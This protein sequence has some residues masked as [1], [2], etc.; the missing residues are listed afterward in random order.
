MKKPP[1]PGRL[2]VFPSLSVLGFYS[3][4]CIILPWSLIT[5][6]QKYKL[7]KFLRKLS[8]IF[9]GPE[10]WRISWLFVETEQ[11]L[12]LLGVVH[13]AEDTTS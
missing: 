1:F 4:R 3:G 2:L 5:P 10:H 6:A 9:R 13:Q 8:K 7:V 12:A 11:H